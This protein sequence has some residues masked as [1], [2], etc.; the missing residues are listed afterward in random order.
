MSPKLQCTAI[1][2]IALLILC[3]LASQT[4]AGS[5]AKLPE[6]KKAVITGITEALPEKAPKKA[7]KD[8]KI[9]VIWKC[10]GFYHSVIPT[11]NKAIELLGE[12]TGVYKATF[13]DDLN[14][15]TA[16]NLKHYDAV[17]LNNTTKL[18][19]SDDQKVALMDFIQGGKG[20]IGIHGA[21]DNFYKWPE[22]AA[23]M[24]GQFGGHPWGAGGTWAFK[25]DEPKHPLNKSF[26]G[27]GFKL[28]DEIYQLKG[29]LYSRKDRKVLLSL[30]M[31]DPATAGR[32][33]NREN[34]DKDYAVSWIKPVGKGRLFYCS[35]GHN[36]V[37]YQ[38]PAVLEHYLAGIQYALGDLKADD[39]PSEK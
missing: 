37:V 6:V 4:F 28:K 19:L 22:G 21:T 33:G 39:S 3:A 18:T 16:E 38:T 25:I 35:L 13:T 8:R 24:G 20:I 26:N 17:L 27:E 34:S 1:P 30:D 23:M 9:L 31:S 7:K 29:P 5:P 15:I 12:K 14:T 2:T 11:G 32:K 36:E 10:Q